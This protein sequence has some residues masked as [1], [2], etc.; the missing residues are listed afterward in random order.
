MR[1]AG[2]VTFLCFHF[3][4]GKKRSPADSSGH[5]SSVLND[6]GKK[7]FPHQC[8][9]INLIN[10]LPIP[11]EQLFSDVLENC[12]SLVKF[13]FSHMFHIDVSF[14]FL[15]RFIFHIRIQRALSGS[16]QIVNLGYFLSNLLFVINFA[17][18]LILNLFLW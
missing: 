16:L 9:W 14:F 15:E 4:S 13:G 6:F 5:L 2:A 10:V 7:W 17:L 12:E 8:F 18:F 11:V 3:K 1:S